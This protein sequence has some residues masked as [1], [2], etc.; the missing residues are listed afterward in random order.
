MTHDQGRQELIRIADTM[1]MRPLAAIEAEVIT[2]AL[3]RYPERGG[4]I[5]VMRE[6]GIPRSTFYRKIKQIYGD[7]E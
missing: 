3:A 6:L 5:R 7:P 2:V 4:R 1:G